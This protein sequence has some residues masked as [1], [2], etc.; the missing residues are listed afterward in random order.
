MWPATLFWSMWY[1][2]L[3]ARRGRRT[4]V[5][6]LE[7]AV[8]VAPAA[9]GRVGDT[10]LLTDLGERGAGA[11]FDVGLTQLADDLFGRMTLPLRF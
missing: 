6:G 9:I 5:F 1:E 4:L 3:T 10:E 2:S 8:L 11:Q 7:A